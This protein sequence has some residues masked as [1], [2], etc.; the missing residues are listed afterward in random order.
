MKTIYKTFALL[1]I[2]A[3]FAA[4]TDSSIE[5]VKPA[6]QPQSAVERPDSVQLVHIVPFHDNARPQSIPMDTPE[7]VSPVEPQP[8]PSVAPVPQPTGMPMYVS[9]SQ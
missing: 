5:P 1:L 4:C 7:A 2:V 6:L 8:R 3:S 9:I